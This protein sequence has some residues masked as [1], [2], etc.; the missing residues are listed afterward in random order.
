M[1]PTGKEKFCHACEASFPAESRAGFRDACPQCNAYLHCCLNCRLY[2]PYA[3]HQC[4]SSTTEF[5]QDKQ[6]SNF[7]EEFEW[8]S[9]P[10]GQGPGKG[11]QDKTK[12]DKLFGD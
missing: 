7:C 12:F 8:L 3:H 4:R 9:A 6:K 5:V 2:D 10:G 11:K 1:S